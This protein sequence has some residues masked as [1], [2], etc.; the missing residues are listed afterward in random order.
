VFSETSA[1]SVAFDS[2]VLAINNTTQ[3][4][5]L[6]HRYGI[7][8]LNTRVRVGGVNQAA[9]TLGSA[10]VSGTV[11]KL[12]GAYKQNDFAFS[13]NGSTASTD[14]LGDMPTGLSQMEIG[15]RTNSGILTGHI[16]KLAYWPKR[17]SD[18]LLQQLTT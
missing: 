14:S 11:Y 6:D 12:I 4:E 2:T 13:V 18:T 16:R 8:G 3:N 7:A 17:L 9:F 10:P 5:Q 15:R 1:A